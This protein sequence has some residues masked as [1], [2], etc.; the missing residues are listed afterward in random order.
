MGLKT[1]DWTVI[2]LCA[3]CHSWFDNGPSEREHKR[4]FWREHWFMH[5]SGLM[6][7]GLVAPV[8]FSEKVRP[9]KRLAK[10]LPRD[11]PPRA[12]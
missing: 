5:M 11:V 2:P 4:A 12:A 7:A 8:G 9:F 3:T 10:I 6:E 1:P